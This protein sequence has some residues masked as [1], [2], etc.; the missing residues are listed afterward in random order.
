MPKVPIPAA[1]LE[2]AMAR[3]DPPGGEASFQRAVVEY[4]RYCGWKVFWTYNSRHSPP[5]D[6]DLRMVRPPR[7]VFAELKTDKGK[8][9][10]GQAETIE[11][12]KQTPVEVHLWRPSMWPEIERVLAR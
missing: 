4:A 5:D 12:L 7:V 2:E 6:L 8:L 11:L 3:Y 10:P 9:T 1:A